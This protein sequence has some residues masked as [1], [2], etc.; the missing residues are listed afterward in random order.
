VPCLPVVVVVFWNLGHGNNNKIISQNFLAFCMCVY[1]YCL[2]TFNEL[3][4]KI[5]P[6]PNKWIS[7]SF[8]HLIQLA[9]S[10]LMTQTDG[11]QAQASE[12]FV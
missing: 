11:Q 2:I 7:N 8:G 9:S 10:I 1:C 5:E 6:N 12:H 4:A 3:P